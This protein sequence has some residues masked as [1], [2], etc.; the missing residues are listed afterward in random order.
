M[1]D[2]ATYMLIALRREHRA[3]IGPR[4]AELGLHSG[5][6]LAMAELWRS[7]GLTHGELA[8]R[9]RVRPPSVTKILRTLERDGLVERRHDAE[10]G[11]VLRIHL[12]ARGRDLRG[13]VERAW[14]DADRETLGGLSADEAASLRRLLSRSLAAVVRTGATS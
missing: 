7:E 8:G 1:L 3:A 11:R 13:P 10:D 4:L 5:S 6:E 14:R 2:S 12:T 9:L